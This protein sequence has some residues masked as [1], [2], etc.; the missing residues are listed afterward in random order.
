MIK[1]ENIPYFQNNPI[2]GEM[3]T[4]AL[5]YKLSKGLFLIVI[6]FL[7]SN[8]LHAQTYAS[9]ANDTWISTSAWQGGIVPNN[10]SISSETIIN[11]KQIVYYPG[12]H[13]R[14]KEGINTLRYKYGK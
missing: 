11:L 1:R 7:L 4:I 3:K 12:S 13:T 10:G 9:I 5:N 2:P 14:N 6:S 8:S